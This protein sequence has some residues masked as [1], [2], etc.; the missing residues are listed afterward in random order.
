MLARSW[1]CLLLKSREV[2]P[3]GL[4][5]VRVQGWKV[6]E[7]FVFWVSREASHILAVLKL[8]HGCPEYRFP[9]ESLLVIGPQFLVRV[10]VLSYRRL[11][12]RQDTTVVVV[13]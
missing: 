2:L 9:F 6:W 10:K 13:L 4:R 1:S 12:C 7:W 5:A 3:L 11:G 8:R